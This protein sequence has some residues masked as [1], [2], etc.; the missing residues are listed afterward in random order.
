VRLTDLLGATVVDEGGR[1]LGVV[2]DVRLVQDGPLQGTFGAALRVHGLVVGRTSVGAHL[3]FDRANVRGPWLL[4]GLVG[5]VQGRPRYVDWSRIRSIE[6]RL[7]R[8]AA[9]PDGL[10]FAEPAR[11]GWASPR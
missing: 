2:T 3:G 11:E 10:P 9:S 6:P 7:V 4:K 1:L 5:A 8:V